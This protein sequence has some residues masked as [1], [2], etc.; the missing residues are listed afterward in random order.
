MTYL[1]FGFAIAIVAGFV[2][3]KLRL[4][5]WLQNWVRDIQAGAASQ[6]WLAQDRLDMEDRYRLG[7]EAVH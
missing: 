2:I 4:E 6:G 5:D 1:V 7:I 3:G